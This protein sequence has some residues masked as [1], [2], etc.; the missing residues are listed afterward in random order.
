MRRKT[1]EAVAVVPPRLTVSVQALLLLLLHDEAALPLLLVVVVLAV[2]RHFRR[3]ALEEQRDLSLLSPS[4][5]LSSSRVK[6]V[7]LP[8][9]RMA[10]AC[11]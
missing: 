4:P 5:S 1:A 11:D 2:A 3:E 6:S 9:K 8:G 7:R 10:C